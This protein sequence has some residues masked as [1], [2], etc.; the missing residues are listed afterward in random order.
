LS[1][2]F[3]ASRYLEESFKFN[4]LLNQSL[5][6]CWALDVLKKKTISKS[7]VKKR[8]IKYAFIIK[9]NKMLKISS[10]P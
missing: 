5:A 10:A 2:A 8:V 4:P 3:M 7:G 9:L 1:N 6:V